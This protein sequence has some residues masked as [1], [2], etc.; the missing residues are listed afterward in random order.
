MVPLVTPVVCY[1][2]RLFVALCHEDFEHDVVMNNKEMM[3]LRLKNGMKTT[4]KITC[5]MDTVRSKGD[6]RKI[7]YMGLM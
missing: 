4:T 3:E 7:L 6:G 5:R 2:Y 1:P